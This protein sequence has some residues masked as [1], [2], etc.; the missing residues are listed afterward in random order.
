MGLAGGLF[1]LQ[2]LQLL[3]EFGL[4]ETG[5]NGQDDV[6]DLPVDAR[7]P[8]PYGLRV[9]NVTPPLPVIVGL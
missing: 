3:M 2:F 7:K 4:R 9:V 1:V 8:C 5:D 6:P